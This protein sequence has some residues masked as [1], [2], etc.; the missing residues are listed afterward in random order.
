M[1]QTIS[2]DQ[3]PLVIE[4]INETYT[5]EVEQIVEAQIE[6]N[7]AITAI[8][9]DEDRIVGFRYTDNQVSTR[10]L[11]PDDL[12]NDQE[13]DL[14]QEADPDQSV[15]EQISLDLEDNTA[16]KPQPQQPRGDQKFSPTDLASLGA[17]DYSAI[18]DWDEVRNVASE[19]G[20]TWDD[21]AGRYRD[22]DGNLVSADQILNLTYAELDLLNQDVN[23]YCNLL[24]AGDI[25]LKE[26]EMQIARI[27]VITTA[28]FFLFG[29]GGNVERITRDHQQYLTNRIQ[30]QFEFLRN[31]SEDIQ[32]G[33]MSERGLKARTRLYV[34][35]S[36][37]GYS[38]AQE[39][40]HGIGDWPFYAN[41]LGGCD[42]CEECPAE[43]AKGIVRRG[44]LIKIGSRECRWNCCCH[45]EYF[46][47]A[48]GR[49]DKASLLTKKT[50]WL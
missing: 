18:I 5:D 2:S 12:E 38:E 7:G 32:T 49:T 19:Q 23:D 13:P 21:D 41:V 30:R 24:I 28:L 14:E 34:Q 26:W 10:I 29:F 37:L 3:Y 45:Y 6:D 31:F 25:S 27:I 36:Q 35:D 43:T 8:A 48:D 33:K 40:V 9:I 20:W 22:K 39:L 11:N 17:Y 47:T 46:K 50:G 4:L 16:K 44:S 1:P 42:H 15:D